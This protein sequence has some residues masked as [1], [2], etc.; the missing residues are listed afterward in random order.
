MMLADR[1]RDR[2][3]TFK[4]TP[5]FAYV[6]GRSTDSAISRVCSHLHEARSLAAR[7]LPSIHQRKSGAI[8]GMIACWGA[9][10]QPGH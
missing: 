6:G 8:P 3:E 9:V 4:Q 7:A 2:A 5:Q 10:S 1:I